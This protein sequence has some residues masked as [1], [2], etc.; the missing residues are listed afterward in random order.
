MRKI[1]SVIYL[2]SFCSIFNTLSAQVTFTA[3]DVTVDCDDASFCVEISVTN[4]DSI[5]SFQHVYDWD[6]TIAQIQSFTDLMPEG[7]GL[8]PHPDSLAGGRGPYSW[9]N[10]PFTTLADGFVIAEVCMT[11][12]NLGS[13]TFD[14]V[15]SNTTLLRVDGYING[16]LTQDI[17]AV[18][19]PGTIT[20]QD[21]E[22]PVIVCPMDTVIQS[23]GTNVNN[24]GPVSVTD[25]CEI[26]GVSYNMSGAT[27]GSGMDDASGQFFNPG[28][29]TVTYTATDE[30]GNTGDC[31]FDV[32]LVPPPPDTG[33]LQFIPR[34]NLDC[35]TGDVNIEMLVTNFDSIVGMQFGIQWD[36]SMLT[37]IN[38]DNGALPPVPSYNPANDS[39]I[40]F[41][42][43]PFSGNPLTLG[44]SSVIFTMNF[45]LNG[46][47]TQPVLSF[48]SF[49]G[50]P[51]GIG[52]SQNGMDVNLVQDVDFFF[53]PEIINVI[54]NNPPT[55]VTPCPGNINVPSGAGVCDAVVSWTPPTFDDDCGIDNIQSTHDPG[56]TFPVGTT[57]V[58]YTATDIGGNMTSCSFNV[59]VSDQESPI[60]NCPGDVNAGTDPG[61]C[62]STVNIGNAMA[63]DNCGIASI[64]NNAPATFPVGTTIVTWTAFDVN[65]N[66]ATC[67]QNV[68]IT[69]TENP[70]ITCPAD[71]TVCTPSGVNLGTP[72]T[73][74][75]CG[76]SNVSN[77]APGTF[78]IGTT[79][80]TWT[81][82]DAEGNM[83]TC[84]QQVTVD[85]VP[86]T[87]TCPSDITVCHSDSVSLG[88]PVTSD[89]CGVASVIN[90]APGNYPNGT[91]IVTWTATDLAGNMST[92]T[93]SVTIDDTEAPMITCPNVDAFDADPNMCSTV[94]NNNLAPIVTDC[95]DFTVNYVITGATTGS[96]N[97]DATGTEFFVGQSLLTYYATDVFGNVDSCS[98]LIQV[99]DSQNP[100]INC[101]NDVVIFVPSGTIDTVVNNIGA[102]AS[103][104]CQVDAITYST[105]GALVISGNGD[106]SGTA[107]PPGITN[108]TYVVSDPSGNVDSCSFIV[109]INETMNDML[110]C[111]AN[112]AVTNDIDECSAVVN[113]IGPI[114]L[115]APGQVDNI[116]YTLSG[117]TSGSGM[118]DA[119]GTSFNVG[120]TIVEYILTDISNNMDTCSFTV[121]VVD[122][123]P[124]EWQSCPNDITVS[125]TLPDCRAIVNWAIPLPSDNC[126]LAQIN[127]THN[128]N[129]T[130]DIGT[131]LVTYEAID[132]A[133]NSATCSFSVTVVDNVPPS[134]SCPSDISIGTD[135][136]S[137]EGTASWP[138]IFAMDNC[139]P[140]PIVSCNFNSGDMFPIGVTTVTCTASDVSGNIST[141][142][143]NVIVVDSE[144]PMVTNC[145]PDLTINTNQNE[146]EAIFSW[147]EP[148]FIDA[149][150]NP[151][152]VSSTHSP[153][154]TFQVGTTAIFYIGVDAVG[155]NAICSF[156]L[157]VVDNEAPEPVCPD[158][159]TVQSMVKECGI[160]VTWPT[161]TATDNCDNTVSMIPDIPPGTFFPVGTTTV[162][163]TAMDNS[164]N[165]AQCTFDVTVVDLTPPEFVCHENIVIGIDGTIVDDN[166]N[167]IVSITPNATCD[168]ITINYL[169]PPVTDNCNIDSFGL[170]AG[171][172][173][174]SVF[175]VGTTSI[176]YLAIDDSDNSAA[177]SFDIIVLPLPAVMVTI[178][179]TDTVCEGQDISLMTDVVV[180]GAMFSW[181]NLNS[182][183]TDTA[184]VPII[185]D[186]SLGILVYIQLQ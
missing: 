73:S 180:P 19:N 115:I 116:Q 173:S 132:S 176:M 60:I 137:C 90:D 26:S 96:G 142:T 169:D 10:F 58:T 148:T 130:F 79:T 22:D 71:I 114:I 76:V 159:I 41:L 57:M 78:P 2:L 166:S 88:N 69:D 63:T 184:A 84:T 52:Q 117:A 165:T 9:F 61:Q 55:I 54:D 162:T 170:I 147:T 1:I 7:F 103:D 113:G 40:L 46:T 67:T 45:T 183:W 154:D 105:T 75:N 39:A 5:T 47:L 138:P 121:T 175:P 56:D 38:T 124:P 151:V 168:S 150:S 30:A 18:Y 119:S 112:Q 153:G 31:S 20:V 74:D 91:T 101:P 83:A 100:V 144:P 13:T 89:S 53:M 118:T 107:F 171:L 125:A 33:A 94:V 16:V 158:D 129:D 86:P 177:C 32:T 48:V 4:F 167:A 146:C 140:S 95:N 23:N 134:I 163:Y 25:N 123:Q 66:S 128:P 174:G 24:I 65:G 11:P 99:N 35:S 157:T 49:M 29:T 6:T 15:G 72:T 77:D 185:T 37:Y 164:G 131:T 109:N 145:P 8:A 64:T 111:P 34:V 44:D 85:D 152:S 122:A 87:I 51:I 133:G 102:S 17:P 21:I 135:P 156:N 161:P 108:I 93:Q 42:W 81:V 3:S 160:V 98:I 43:F 27:T 110:G 82:T 182:G 80:V 104:N 143:F 28:T 36:T 120:I 149:C 178:N 181:E 127:T 106:I 12:N 62:S 136:G 59:T 70:T 172:P 97:D 186:I 14:F 141:C 92:C 179:P 139:D 126:N 155:N 50:I 68:I